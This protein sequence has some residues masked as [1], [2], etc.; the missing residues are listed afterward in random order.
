MTMYETIRTELLSP[1]NLWIGLNSMGTVY[2]GSS[3]HTR[4]L[5]TILCAN[6]SRQYA[7]SATETVEVDVQFFGAVTAHLNDQPI[8]LGMVVDYKRRY[9]PTLMRRFRF[10]LDVEADDV[11]T[12]SRPPFDI[13]IKHLSS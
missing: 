5:E 1:P 4:A 12:F 2:I 10:R 6:H 3:G 13:V 8:S 7:F 9:D 11:L